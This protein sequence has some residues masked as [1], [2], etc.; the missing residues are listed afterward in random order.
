MWRIRVIWKAVVW[1]RNGANV[2]RSRPMADRW[3]ETTCRCS[4]SQKLP[5]RALGL[6][7]P[8]DPEAQPLIQQHEKTMHKLQAVSGKDFDHLYLSHEVQMH[9]RLL[10]TVVTLA[11]Q[12]Q[13][14]NSQKS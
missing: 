11:G 3:R 2:W 8:W 14:L 4:R 10:Q 13:D 5:P 7:L 6:C 9:Q 1:P 12:T